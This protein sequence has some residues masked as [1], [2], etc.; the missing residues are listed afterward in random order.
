MSTPV[1]LREP[2]ALAAEITALDAAA[3][4]GSG[5]HEGARDALRWLLRGGP[6][7]L[8]G[9]SIDLPIPLRAVVAEL[10]A[11]GELAYGR[12]SGRRDY[13]L[14]LEHALMWA[15]FATAA[16]PAAPG[17]HESSVRSYSVPK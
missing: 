3:L 15:E 14:G 13:A 1:A 6:G 11:A 4:A 16:R 8:T 10:S 5:F 17:R 7:P 12:P 2:A 9:R